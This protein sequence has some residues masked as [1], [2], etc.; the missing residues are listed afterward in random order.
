MVD[1]MTYLLVI[2]ESFLT[3]V[4][5]CNRPEA[6]AQVTGAFVERVDASEPVC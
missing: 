2:I 4:M 3:L 5:S 1:T 6:Q